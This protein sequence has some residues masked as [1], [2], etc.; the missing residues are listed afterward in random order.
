MHLGSCPYK[1]GSRNWAGAGTAT[2]NRCSQEIIIPLSLA[3]NLR[4]SLP[5]SRGQSNAARRMCTQRPG[6]ALHARRCV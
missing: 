4:Y 5:Q 6:I 2:S 3:R 1:G